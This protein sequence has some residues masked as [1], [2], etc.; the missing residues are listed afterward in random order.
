[1][2]FQH[3]VEASSA[4]SGQCGLKLIINISQLIN[5]WNGSLFNELNKLCT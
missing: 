1:M 5:N 4:A 2:D 3:Y